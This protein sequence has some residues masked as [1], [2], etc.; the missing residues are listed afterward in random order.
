MWFY[1]LHEPELLNIVTLAG[2]I[3]SWWI[4]D[5]TFDAENFCLKAEAVSS[6]ISSGSSL[7][8]RVYFPGIPDTEQLFLSWKEIY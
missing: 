3:D 5:A 1:E 7:W 8:L 2:Q 6:A 4:A